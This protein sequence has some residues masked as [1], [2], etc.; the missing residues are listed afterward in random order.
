[1]TNIQIIAYTI[2]CII[3]KACGYIAWHIKS[4]HFIIYFTINLF[5][6]KIDIF[7]RIAIHYNPAYNIH[8]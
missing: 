6:F 8:R 1:M 7:R 3:Y 2:P 4:I 5:R